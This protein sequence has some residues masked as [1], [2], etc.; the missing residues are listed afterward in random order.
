MLTVESLLLNDDLDSY[1]YLKSSRKTVQGVSDVN[2][3][4][5]LKVPALTKISNYRTR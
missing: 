3:F 2:D 5:A 4:S 1:R